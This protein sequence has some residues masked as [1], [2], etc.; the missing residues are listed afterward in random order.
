MTGE[1]RGREH[2]HRL[3]QDI[4]RLVSTATN[5][6]T[7]FVLSALALLEAERKIQPAID[8]LAAW[9]LAETNKR[10]TARPEP[11]TAEGPRR[12]REGDA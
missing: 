3:M 5:D 12:H 7:G 4:A 8:A 11:D 9:E 6:D 1:N 2:F 10:A